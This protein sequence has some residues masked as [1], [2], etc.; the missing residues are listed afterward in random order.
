[1]LCSFFLLLFLLLPSCKPLVDAGGKQ[2]SSKEHHALESLFSHLLFY[3]GGAY[4]LFGSKPMSFESLSDIPEKEKQE[5]FFFSSH[6]SIKNM[7]NFSENWNTWERLKNQYPMPRFLLFQ[8]NSPSFSPAEQSVFLVNI[9]AT[10]GILQKYYQKFRAAAG[11]DFD[12]LDIVFEIQDNHSVFWN[13]ILT[14]EDLFGLLLGFGE[15]NAWFFTKVKAWQDLENRHPNDQKNDFLASLSMQAPG[16]NSLSHFDPSFPLPGFICYAEEESFDL[17]RRYE[18]ERTM[19]KKIYHGKDLVQTT[20]D[21]LTSKDLP[22]DPD[23]LYKEKMI[24]ELG[25][26]SQP[27]Q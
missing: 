25:I 22:A 4:T 14:R 27:P 21:R 16:S 26:Q 18:N 3:E 9:T 19:I 11:E 6:P 12:P 15:E 8:R 23:Q 20:L 24:K 13:K 10:T 17:V 7:L 2:L 1:M 5:F